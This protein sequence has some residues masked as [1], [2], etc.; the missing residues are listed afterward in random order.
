M[1]SESAPHIPV[2]LKQ[3]LEMLGMSPGRTWVDATA[4]AGGH[5]RAIVNAAGTGSTVFGIDQ[6]TIS[7]NI[8]REKLA[9]NVAGTDLRLVHANFKSI[10]KVLHEQGVDT[11]SG[12]ILAD[13]GVSSMQLDNPERGFSFSKDGPLDMRM[14]PTAPVTAEDLINK[15]SEKDLADIIYK[16][17]EER[18]SRQIARRIVESRPLHTT[19]ELAAVVSPAVRRHRHGKRDRDESHPATRTFQALRIAVNDEL[20]SIEQFLRTAIG[21]LEPGARLVVI[22][23]HSLEDRIVKQIFREAAASCICPPRH[24]VCMCSKKSELKIL[25]PKPLLPDHEEVLANPRSRSAKL[26][27]GARVA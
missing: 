27:A 19:G 7:L 16:Y 24:P 2:M 3:S 6:D 5:L 23:F 8:L 22:T 26:R 12:G 4:G 18:L 21:M 1:E 13:L 17:G 10:D 25:T 15:L 11:I 14:D 9:P 20:S